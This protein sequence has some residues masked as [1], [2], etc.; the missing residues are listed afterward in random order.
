MRTKLKL[1]SSRALGEEKKCTPFVSSAVMMQGGIWTIEVHILA[2]HEAAVPI[3]LTD[4]SGSEAVPRVAHPSAK[5]RF[6]QRR[7]VEHSTPPH[8]EQGIVERT[9]T[10]R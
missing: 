6:R 4:L 10:L 8:I 9:Q 1:A 7:P 2:T 3:L 5:G